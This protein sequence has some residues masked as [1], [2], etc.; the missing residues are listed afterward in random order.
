MRKFGWTLGAAAAL[1]L[2]LA[3]CAQRDPASE[4]RVDPADG[5]YEISF[6]AGG[7]LGAVMPQNANGPG[8]DTRSVCVR[9]GSGSTFAESIAKGAAWH[10][11]CSNSPAPRQGNALSGTMTCPLD[12]ERVPGGRL[13]SN[14][15]GAVSADGVEVEMVSKFEI[16]EAVFAA[17]RPEQASEMRQA[18]TLM[19]NIP[20]KIVGRRTGDCTS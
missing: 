16:P 13:V 7:A 15:T 9:N 19:E 14:Y 1:T 18:L 11:S 17:M 6:E 2:V 4:E 3:G 12:Q 10:P 5:Q 8:S 20:I